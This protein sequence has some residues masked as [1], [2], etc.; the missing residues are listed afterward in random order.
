MRAN[1][2]KPQE[3]KSWVVLTALCLI[4]LWLPVTS[5]DWLESAGWIHSHEDSGQDAPHEAADGVC[6]LEHGVVSLKAPTL[7]A[8]PSLPIAAV[9]LLSAVVEWSFAPVTLVFHST[10]PPGS[11]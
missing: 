10:A 1:V 5:H 2:N 11:A 6:R 8:Q 4:T 9:E 3:V 7:V